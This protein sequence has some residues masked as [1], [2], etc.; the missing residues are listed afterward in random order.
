MFPDTVCLKHR[1][2]ISEL[3]WFIDKSCSAWSTERFQIKTQPTKLFSKILP[4][5][6]Q[7]I[8][9]SIHPIRFGI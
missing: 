9:V 2:N 7:Q 8:S 3:V 1:L 4:Y 6:V 5:G